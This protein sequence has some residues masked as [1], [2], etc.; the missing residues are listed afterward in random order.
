MLILRD[1]SAHG[2]DGA[3]TVLVRAWCCCACRWA[4]KTSRRP[5]VS[6]GTRSAARLT[7][8]IVL[9]S[10]LSMP[11][12][13]KSLAAVRARAVCA[14]KHRGLCDSRSRTKM[15]GVPL[16]SWATR[17]LAVAHEGHESAIR[18]DASS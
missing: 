5:L 10:A 1:W 7:K 6:A 16:L 2:A 18:A 13:E 15:S 9:P 14:D 11:V 17:S 4:A 8:T 3:A 12:K